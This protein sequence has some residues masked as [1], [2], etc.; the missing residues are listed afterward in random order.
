[1]TCTAP[2]TDFVAECFWPGV[3]EA[4]LR[5]LDARAGASAAELAAAGERVRYLGS[6]LMR[7]D[8]VVLCLFQGSASRPSAGPPS[9]RRSHS[10][11][12]S[13]RPR[14]PW[15]APDNRPERRLH[16][17]TS[18]H[19]ASPLL[20]SLAVAALAAGAGYAARAGSAWSRI[21]GPA[22]PGAQ[23][24]LAR[25]AD[26]VLHVIWNRGSAP[27]SIFETRFS[28]AGKTARHLDG[29]DRLGRQR[30]ARARRHARQ[31]AAAVRPR[32]G[33]HQHVHGACR[34]RSWSLQSGSRLG[35]RGRRVRLRDRRD[36]DEGRPAGHRLAR[37]S[38]PK[39][40]RRARS[41]RTPT[42]AA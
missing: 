26:G 32:H 25:T 7:E 29:R 28:A 18:P 42:R 15:P 22:Q 10:S 41:R 37:H 11:G 39:A 35:R 3:D 27:T 33:R 16:A 19:L 31:D 12:S 1:M 2:A 13:R 24:G 30:R 36:A 8:E 23:L 20:P 34:R 14:S 9:R 6:M 4:A 38:P 5:E 21:S 17:P 40:S